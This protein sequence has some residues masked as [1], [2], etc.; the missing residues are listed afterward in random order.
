MCAGMWLWY[1]PFLLSIWKMCRVFCVVS[2]HLNIVQWLSCVWLFVT[3]W[4]ATFHTPLSSTFKYCL[5]LLERKIKYSVIKTKY[6][7]LLDIVFGLWFF[8]SFLE[9]SC[10]CLR[11]FACVFP[12]RNII[13]TIN[14]I[15][16]FTSVVPIHASCLT[17]ISLIFLTNYCFMS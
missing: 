6:V 5:K 3:A 1:C 9:A 7:C 8:V 2:Q 11:T 17:K 10:L 16:Y 13:S 14:S 4:T 15:L 12:I